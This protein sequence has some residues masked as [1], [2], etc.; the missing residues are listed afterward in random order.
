MGPVQKQWLAAL[1]SGKYL[2]G[3]A[4]LLRNDRYCCLGVACEMLEL[5][6]MDGI[7][8]YGDT[9]SARSMPGYSYRDLGLHSREG[10]FK[11]KDSTNAVILNHGT[12]TDLNDFSGLDFSEIADLIEQNEHLVFAEEK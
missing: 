7:Y 10:R 9:F 2:Q 8:F 6:R 5:K 1:R 3:G 11:Y 4:F 12:L